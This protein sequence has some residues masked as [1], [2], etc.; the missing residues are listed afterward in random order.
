MM[1]PKHNPMLLAAVDAEVVVSELKKNLLK[2][3]SAAKS[4][5]KWVWSSFPLRFSVGP[6]LLACLQENNRPSGMTRNH[7]Y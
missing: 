1:F 6:R 7:S 5:E 3:I 4:L 2:R